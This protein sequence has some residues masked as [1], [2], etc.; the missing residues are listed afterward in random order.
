[1]KQSDSLC[2]VS[3]PTPTKMR[4]VNALQHQ[5]RKAGFLQPAGG[6]YPPASIAAMILTTETRITDV[7]VPP[8]RMVVGW[9]S[10]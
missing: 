5:T 2:R 4:K 3:K 7:P 6:F 9:I 1:M 8:C 10:K